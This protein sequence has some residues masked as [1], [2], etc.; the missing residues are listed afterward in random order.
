[1]NNKLTLGKMFE[2]FLIKPI[3]N[4]LDGSNGSK[5]NLNN[6][7]SVKLL[8]MIV[9]H[10][11]SCLKY[12]KQIKG[13]AVSFFQMEPAT[14]KYLVGWLKSKRPRLLKSAND[15]SP[16]PSDYADEMI[17]FPEYAIAIAR[18]NFLRFSESIPDTDEGIA[19]YAK[20]Y[21]N[22]SAGKASWSDYLNA[23]NQFMSM[24]AE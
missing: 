23:Y 1:M 8:M 19:K 20:K 6:E 3:L 10:E 22:T 17:L 21:W 5:K 15:F 16:I 4:E 18:L 12:S 9:A 7:K 11:S 13:P 24:E 2:R 14:Y